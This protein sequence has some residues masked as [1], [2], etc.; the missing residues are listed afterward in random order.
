[1]SIGQ[2]RNNSDRREQKS[3]EKFLS[4]QLTGGEWK[5]RLYIYMV[6]HFFWCTFFIPYQKH[7]I[8]RFIEEY[9]KVSKC[10]HVLG[11][12]SHW[13]ST[14]KPTVKTV[15]TEHPVGEEESLRLKITWSYLNEHCAMKMHRHSPSER[16]RYVPAADKAQVEFRWVS[17]EYTNIQFSVLL[18]IYKYTCKGVHLQTKLQQPQTWPASSRPHRQPC[19]RSAIFFLTFVSI[20]LSS[21]QGKLRRTFKL[22]I[23]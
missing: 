20:K 8:Q 21:Q 19:Y 15:K 1:M 7:G 11:R 10:N 9:Y 6:L 5:V 3:W 17:T 23:V 4:W 12:D 22:F 2:W 18:C 13:T 16:S 14:G